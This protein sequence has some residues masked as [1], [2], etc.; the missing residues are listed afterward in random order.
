[1]IIIFLV[2][3][4]NGD[5]DIYDTYKLQLLSTIKTGGEIV[6][7]VIDAYGKRIFTCDYEEANLKEWRS[8][9]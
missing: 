9:K 7:L 5:L 1:M 6:S 3:Y 2:A 4:K 8:G